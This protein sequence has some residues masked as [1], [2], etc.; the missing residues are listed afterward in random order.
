[1]IDQLMIL[2]FPFLDFLPFGILRYWLFRDKLR[3]RFKYVILLMA[4]SA[5]IN[6]G[7]FYY[8]NLSGYEAAAAVTTIIRYGFLVGNM[9]LSFV[10]IRDTLPKQMFTYLLLMSWSF[11]IFGNANFIESRYFWDFSD[12]HPYLIYNLARIALLVVTYPFMV[13]FLH[14]TVSDALKIEDK[15]MWGYLWLIPLFST[16]FG[17]LYCTVSDV[18]AYASWQFMVS[19]YLMLFG[20]CYVSYVVLKVLEISRSRTQLEAALKYADQSLRAQSKEYDRLAIHMAEMR[21]AR[22]DL[23]QHL[24][25]VQSYL[26]RDDKEGLAEYISIYK[27]EI[28]LDTMEL[29][30][31]NDVVNAIVSYYAGI[32]REKGILLDAKIKYPEHCTVADTDITVLIGNLLENAVEACVREMSEKD[33]QL[34]K[35]IHMRIKRHDDILLIMVSN[36]CTKPVTFI[37]D[38]PLSSKRSGAGIG[39]S[40]VIE[41]AGRYHGDTEFLQKDGMFYASVMLHLEETVGKPVK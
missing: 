17:M 22:H 19:R 20:T 29:Y 34:G 4:A 35:N 40:S 1:M 5:V 30:S 6:S 21:K 9:A 13:H 11:F 15:K 3:I 26:D 10:I 33:T 24:A 41:I 14:H 16:L 32:A 39:I 2:L 23:R 31:R 37:G 7:I 28:P 8:V 25:V 18:Y 36:T 27:T 38:L 12:L